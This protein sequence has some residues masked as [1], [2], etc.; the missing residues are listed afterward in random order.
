MKKQVAFF[1]ALLLQV[2]LLTAQSSKSQVIGFYN[3][4]NLFDTVDN[5]G[6]KDE[7]Y[8]PNGKKQWTGERYSNKLQNMSFVLNELG[9]EYQKKGAAII[10]VCEVENKGV[11][12]DL[13]AHDNLKKKKWAIIHGDSPDKRGIDVAM[14]Y[15]PKLFEPLSHKYVNP[16]VTREG[17][18]VF[19]RDILLVT[20][21]LKG[22]DTIH[23]L[24]NHWPSR[25]GG[26]EKSR[27]GRIQAA[28][29]N[30]HLMDSIRMKDANARIIVMGDLNDDPTNESVK[31]E[32]KSQAE[33]ANTK[34][35][36]MYN[37]FE[38][39]LAGD[40]GSLK[41]R[42]EWN[43]FDQILVSRSVATTGAFRFVKAE[44]YNRCYLIQQKGKYSGN[45]H[46]TFG[47]KKYL[48]G[49]SDHL[50]TMIVLDVN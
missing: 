16:K 22:E 48:N 38:N 12:E 11:L 26:E 46:R 1:F 21:V 47:G 8:T 3:L 17:K 42:G 32:L 19:T 9:V 13:V 18:E 27:P 2:T 6:V 30:K 40:E 37:P 5:E 7:E 43:L 49:Y 41:Y 24:V 23:V 45:P 10:G 50:P 25:W 35:D 33:L 4:E 28:K 29:M 44:V 15:N 20:G 14:L 39:I 36:E 31:N 34:K